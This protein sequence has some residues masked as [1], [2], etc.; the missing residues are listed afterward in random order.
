MIKKTLSHHMRH[1]LLSVVGSALCVLGLAVPMTV[2][3]ASAPVYHPII[4]VVDTQIRAQNLTQVQAITQAFHAFPFPLLLPHSIPTKTSLTVIQVEHPVVHLSP[5]MVTLVYGVYGKVTT[6]EVDESPAPIHYVT[7]HVQAVKING[8]PATVY[9][10]SLG[11]HTIVYITWQI[12][13]NGYSITS[14]LAK[15]HLKIPILV[16][17]AAS[18]R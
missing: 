14:D 11:I 12:G 16:N 1:L 15:S 5:G 7:N 3:A 10:I 2:Q 17:I 13:Q 18:V 4:L 8:R 6:F 9:T